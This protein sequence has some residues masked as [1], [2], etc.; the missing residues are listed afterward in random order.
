MAYATLE[1]T[2][3]YETMTA[4]MTRNAAL[5]VA[6]MIASQKTLTKNMVQY[7]IFIPVV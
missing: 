3:A 5:M 6:K 4:Q 2:Y 7:Y 1:E